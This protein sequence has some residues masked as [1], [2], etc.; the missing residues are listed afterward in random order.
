MSD[1]ETVVEHATPARIAAL[2]DALLPGLISGEMRVGD[3]E[4]F[5]EEALS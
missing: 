5:M 4:M 3:A 2:R 1:N